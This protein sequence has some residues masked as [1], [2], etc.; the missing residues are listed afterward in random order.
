MSI[1]L[2]QTMEWS[3]LCWDLSFERIIELDSLLPSI[4]KTYPVK[5]ARNEDFVAEGHSFLLW[6]PPHSELNGWYDKR[7]SEILRSYVL[8]GTLKHKDPSGLAFEFQVI[9]RTRLIDFFSRTD[10]QKQSPLSYIGLANGSSTLQWQDAYGVIKSKVGDFIYLSGSE[11]ET[12]LDAILSIDNDKMCLHYSATLHNP[13]YYETIIA[14]YYLSSE[15]S[16]V[17]NRLLAQA[18][19]VED[20]SIESLDENHV[21]GAEYW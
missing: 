13:S 5:F 3:K 15:E 2:L 7:P 14:K 6:Q 20:I 12:S 9:A 1:K 8:E 4:G 17:F 19:E 10:E 16:N 21:Y 11:C 18:K